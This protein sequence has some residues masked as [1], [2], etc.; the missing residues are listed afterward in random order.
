MCWKVLHKVSIVAK[1]GKRT[2][3][4]CFRSVLLLTGLG[5]CQ[6]CWWCGTVHSADRYEEGLWSL[7]GDG[8]SQLFVQEWKLRQCFSEQ[9]LK[10]VNKSSDWSC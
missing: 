3:R 4:F 1:T 6:C 2:G 7:C 10:S 8:I 9:S 5:K